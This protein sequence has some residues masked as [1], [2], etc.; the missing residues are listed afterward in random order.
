MDSQWF[1]GIVLSNED[2]DYQQLRSRD[3]SSFRKC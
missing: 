3:I 2:V 1:Q